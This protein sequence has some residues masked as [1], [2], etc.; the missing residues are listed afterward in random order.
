MDFILFHDTEQYGILSVDI[1]FSDIMFYY[2]VS[3]NI[4]SA[5]HNLYLDMEQQAIKKS[6][7]E[8]NEILDYT[9]SHDELT[10]I[11]NRAGI[12]DHMFSYIH[13][14]ENGTAF[15]L[16]MA[17]LDHL[18]QIND[19]FGHGEGDFAIRTA[20]EILSSCLP[21]KAPLGRSGGDEFTGIYLK[22]SEQDIPDYIANVKKACEKFNNVSDKPYEIHISVG[23]QEFYY[24]DAKTLSIAMKAADS[25]LYDAKKLRKHSVI[26]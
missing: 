12:M 4:G 5:L 11:Y 26:K 18:K 10:G 1:D 15:I 3:L 2:T 14:N 17:D 19:T 24:E 9:A 7:E 22:K 13:K 20:A 6:L 25:S 23:C 16:L 21:D 8:K